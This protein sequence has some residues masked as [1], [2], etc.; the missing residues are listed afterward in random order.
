MHQRTQAFEKVFTQSVKVALAANAGKTLSIPIEIKPDVYVD[1]LP[2]P[3]SYEDA[4]CPRT[5][6][7]LA[8]GYR[9]LQKK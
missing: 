6:P 8:T 1:T 7:K 4:C 5:I 9:R 3:K 2:L